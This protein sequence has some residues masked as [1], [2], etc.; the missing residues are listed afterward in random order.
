M[1]GFDTCYDNDRADRAIR[2]QAAAERR[3]VLTRDRQLLICRDVTHGCYV[4]ALKPEAQLREVVDRLQLA[5]LARPFT[6]CLC[7]NAALEAVEKS[8][9]LARLP[10]RV[11]RAQ[12]SFKRCP[13][14]ERVY[15]PGDHHRRMS[16]A[17]SAVLAYG[18][19]TR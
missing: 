16:E 8:A 14:C 13:A 9:V 10:P 1:L 17:L 15:W 18:R 4:H 3:I 5:A 6:R 2:A 12:H 19:E 11:A 7:C